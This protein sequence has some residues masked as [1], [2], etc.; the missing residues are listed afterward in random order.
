MEVL[1]GWSAQRASLAVKA[2]SEVD[3]TKVVTVN[4]V[5]PKDGL[6]SPEGTQTKRLG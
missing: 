5:P 2:L 3:K 6:V 4:A 1:G